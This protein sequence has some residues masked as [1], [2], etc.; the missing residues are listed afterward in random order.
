MVTIYLL[1]SLSSNDSMLSS[2]LQTCGQSKATHV[3]LKSRVALIWHAPPANRKLHRKI[4]PLILPLEHVEDTSWLAKSNLL[5]R[6][7]RLQ[8]VP[9]ITAAVNQ[10]LFHSGHYNSQEW[11]HSYDLLEL[12]TSNVF[13]SNVVDVSA[14]KTGANGQI[15]NNCLLFSCLRAC[16]C[17]PSNWMTIAWAVL[18]IRLSHR[19]R[20]YTASHKECWFVLSKNVIP[21]V[22]STHK[23]IILRETLVGFRNAQSPSSDVLYRPS[24]CHPCPYH[25]SHLVRRVLP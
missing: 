5:N 22:P 11:M 2:R 25:P 18:W 17:W 23:S 7:G 20:I 10:S 4:D 1:G 21:F 24:P 15:A 16:L 19:L 14:G 12:E 3:V 6:S 9:N 8:A 13:L